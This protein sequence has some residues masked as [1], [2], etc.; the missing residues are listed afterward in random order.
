MRKLMMILALGCLASVGAPIP[1]ASQA[2]VEMKIAQAKS[3]LIAY[4][5]AGLSSTNMTQEQIANNAATMSVAN[6]MPL[7]ASLSTPTE[8][9]QNPTGV[10]SYVIAGR[11]SA[12]TNSLPNGARLTQK[13]A[14]TYGTNDILLTL[15]SITNT[16]TFPSAEL[17]AP[18]NSPF[19]EGAG[20][21]VILVEVQE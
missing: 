16:L 21:W 19:F 2:W 14:Y 12:F 4:I 17:L 3:D 13:T 9:I 18:T 10:V 1:Q 15:G 20:G 8:Y 6:M 11:S 5:D 7:A